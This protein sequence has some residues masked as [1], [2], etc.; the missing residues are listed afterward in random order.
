MEAYKGLE[1]LLCAAE[2]LVARGVAFSLHLAGVGP[3]LDRLRARFQ[4][5]PD[6]VIHDRILRPSEAIEEFQ[7]ACVVVLPYLDAS[8]SGVTAAA[9]GN[10]RPVV[11]SRV[12]GI[13]DVVQ[14][15]INGLLVD[16]N[17]IT[18]LTD[19]L[20]RVL[21][22]RLLLN[23]LRRGAENSAA[24]LMNWNEISA[25]LVGQYRQLLGGQPARGKSAAKSDAD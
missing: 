24:T 22:S 19:A 10:G 5:L 8:Q 9:F 20:T 4:R 11:A 3:E 14:D 21:G 6:V 15:G 25:E 13:S 18:T 16:A 2:S 23:K 17:S 1:V 12:G 7:E